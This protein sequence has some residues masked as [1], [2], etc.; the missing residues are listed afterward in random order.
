MALDTKNWMSLLSNNLSLKDI[1]IP[2]THDSGTAKITDNITKGM[3]HTQNF[4]IDRQLDDGIR[5]LDIRLKL[6]GVELDVYHGPISC[7]INFTHVLKWCNDFLQKNKSETIIMSVKN[8]GLESQPIADAFR[9]YATIYPNLFYRG[10]NVPLLGDV[11]GKIVLF[12]R[13]PFKDFGVDLTEWNSKGSKR[14]DIIASSGDLFNIDD[15][16]ECYDTNEKMNTIIR[17]SLYNAGQNKSSFFITFASI[18]VHVPALHS[19]Y[20]YAWG[21]SGIDPAINPRLFA[22]LTK[23]G[24]SLNRRLGVVVLDFHNNRGKDNYLVNAII[25]SNFNIDFQINA[26]YYI[27]SKSS[28]HF[29]GIAKPNRDNGTP[30]IT[31]LFNN[32]ENQIFRLRRLRGNGAYIIDAKHSFLALQPANGRIEEA[33][34]VQYTVNPDSSLQQWNIKCEKDDWFSITNVATKQCMTVE[35]NGTRYGS[36]IIDY[37]NN[38]RDNQRFRFIPVYTLF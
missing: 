33:P 38:G 36:Y 25:A 34:I 21:G 28:F 12:N 9:R 6:C 27:L 24:T 29:L 7:G 31:C 11:R 19:P 14:F 30:L 4:S 18:A 2:G 20:Q 8:E 16:Y 22:C 1:S 32:E 3:A 5:F 35:S 13:F 10:K 26:Y 37:K 23:T 15:Q 17:S